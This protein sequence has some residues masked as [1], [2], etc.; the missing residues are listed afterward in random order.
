MVEETE[1]EKL[2]AEALALREM[3][4]KEFAEAIQTGETIDSVVGKII[5]RPAGR[6]TS[7]LNIS[8]EID[9]YVAAKGVDIFI[10]EDGNERLEFY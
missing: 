10:D 3:I 9:S 8:K 6:S 4:E 1:T 7:F 2:T 5:R